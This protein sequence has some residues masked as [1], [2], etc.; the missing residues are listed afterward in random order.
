MI[1]YGDSSPRLSRIAQ[2]HFIVQHARNIKQWLI[3]VHHI[4]NR[5]GNSLVNPHYEIKGT[6]GKALTL[7]G[8]ITNGKILISI[9]SAHRREVNMKFVFG[10]L[11][12]PASGRGIINYKNAT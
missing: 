2:S 7:Y 4:L 9:E 6:L 5:N 11:S 10:P 3:E 12:K 8:R 1:P